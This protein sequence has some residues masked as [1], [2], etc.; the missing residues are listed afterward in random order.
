MKAFYGLSFFVLSD[1]EFDILGRVTRSKQTTDGVEYGT[2]TNPMTY[3]YNLSGALIEQKYPSGRVVRNTLDANGD[4]AEVDSKKTSTDFYRPYVNSFVYNA[5]GAVSSLKLGN[6]KFESTTFNSRLQPMQIT[7]GSSVN[8]TGLLKLDYTY[9]TTGNHDNNGNVLTEAIKVPTVTVG[10]TTY[11]GFNALQTYSY[12]SLNRIDD[13]NEVINST[14]TTWRQDFTYDRYG[15]RN[16]NETNTTTL[17]KNCSGT[18]CAADKKIYD[19]AVNTANNRLSTSDGYTFDSSGN[20]TYDPQLRKFIYDAEN[21]QVKVETV[22]SGGTVTEPSANTRMTV[23][24][25]V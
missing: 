15:N 18:V 6:G 2:D 22:N 10:G 13:S 5:A 25:S 23:T 11:N 3:T 7:L 21:K 16:F 1:S 24:E 4:L 14:T 17:P 12:D 8:D 20:T 19:P 9:N